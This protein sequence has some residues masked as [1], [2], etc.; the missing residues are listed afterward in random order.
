MIGDKL[1]KLKHLHYKAC[2]DSK[3]LAKRTI[4]DRFLKDRTYEIAGNRGYDEYQRALAS[5]VYKFFDKIAGS[6][7][8][9]NEQLAEELYKPVIKNLKKVCE[10]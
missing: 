7:I 4:S 6:G 3:D 2:F 1:A 10:I 5:M 9:I 8:S